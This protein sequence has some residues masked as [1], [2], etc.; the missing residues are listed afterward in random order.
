MWRMLQQDEPGDYVVAT[1]ET[2]TIR[3]LLDVAFRAIGVDDWRPYVATD[4]RFLRPAEVDVLTGDASKARNKL[5]W[6]PTLDFQTLIK[7]MV[8]HDLELEARKAGDR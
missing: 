8:D 1:G 4:R 7:V 6:E 5:G 3:E 2:H